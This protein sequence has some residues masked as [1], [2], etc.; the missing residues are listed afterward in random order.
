MDGAV[1]TINRAEEN[2][3]FQGKV[4]GF[5]IFFSVA[6]VVDLYQHPGFE[7]KPTKSLNVLC[8][9]LGS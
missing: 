7:S 8:A 1:L 9:Y 6:F 3:K 5:R 2:I 4:Q